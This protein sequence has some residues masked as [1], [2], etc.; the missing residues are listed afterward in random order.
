MSPQ[1]KTVHPPEREAVRSEL[2]GSMPVRMIRATIR[3][4]AVVVAGGAVLTLVGFLSL[5]G[6]VG[7]LQADP[8]DTVQED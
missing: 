7:A 5:A 3:G 6:V 2:V 1:D 8:S 4:A